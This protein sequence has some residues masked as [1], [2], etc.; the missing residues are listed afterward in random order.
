MITTL[1]PCSFPI[2]TKYFER[3]CDVIGQLHSTVHKTDMLLEDESFTS[4][5]FNCAQS[6][7]CFT[8]RKANQFTGVLFD[9]CFCNL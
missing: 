1:Y 4:T 6:K 8:F 9:L 7:Y 3:N 2:G 5:V